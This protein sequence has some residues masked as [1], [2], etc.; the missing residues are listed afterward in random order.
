MGLVW[1]LIPSV[2]TTPLNCDISKRNTVPLCCTHLYTA[3]VSAFPHAH[4]LISPNECQA[5]V[6]R[7]LL[8]NGV[9]R[10]KACYYG[11]RPLDVVGQCRLDSQAAS[12]INQALTEELKSEYCCRCTIL[13]RTWP[14]DHEQPM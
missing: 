8:E 5:G 10:G 1:I 12:D 4:L 11:Q 7:W 14:L 9:D 6:V 13:A 2:V 3:V